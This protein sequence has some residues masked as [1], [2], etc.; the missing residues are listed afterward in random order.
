M[1]LSLIIAGLK[2]TRSLL[3]GHLGSRLENNLFKTVCMS[4]KMMRYITRDKS[5]EQIGRKGRS[6]KGFKDRRNFRRDKPK[7]GPKNQQ[8]NL[9]KNHTSHSHSLNKSRPKIKVWWTK[10]G[11]K[12][13]IV[14]H[15]WQTW[16]KRNRERKKR[17]HF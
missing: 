13:T 11:I 12:E 10:M 1:T 5:K 16:V 9:W 3:K 14:N 17:N 7:S 6:A 4:M 15:G 8:R 2:I